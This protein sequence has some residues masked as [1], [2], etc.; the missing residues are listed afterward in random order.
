MKP[1]SVALTLVFFVL[2]VLPSITSAVPPPEGGWEAVDKVFGQPGKDLPGDV[3][4][5]GW[6]RADLHVTV[7]GVPVQPGLALGAWAAFKRTGQGD[8]AITMG[9]L[10]LLESE[11]EPVL[12]E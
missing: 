12:G 3:H 8:D 2:L 1:K 7:G 4:R 6:P 10:V 5:F 11:L 9:D